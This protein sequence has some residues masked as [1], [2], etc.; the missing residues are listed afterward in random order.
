VHSFSLP[1]T[2]VPARLTLTAGTP[3]RG[4]IFVMDRVPHH[5]GPETPLEMLNRADA[6]FPFWPDGHTDPRAVLLVAKAHT[7]S[8]SIEGEVFADPARQSA[9][10][11]AGLELVLEGG[12]SISGR[13][14]FELPTGHQRLLDY[15]NASQE[16][17][18]A[19]SQNG[20]THY[21]NRVH[22]LYARPAD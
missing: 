7:V 8:V 16:A 18:F 11:T 2:T 15:L 5:D 4:S 6:F 19:V 13:A 1:R 12:S 3:S 14:Q 10:Q 21:V 20:T 9:A 17:F 22:V